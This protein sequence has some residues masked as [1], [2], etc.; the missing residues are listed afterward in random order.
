M[1][2]ATASVAAVVLAALSVLQVMVAA[3]R[4]YG[5]LVWGGAH[6]VLPRRLRVGSALSVLVYAAI[7]VAL[8]WR[9]GAFGEPGIVAAVVAWVI[10]GYFALGIVLNALSRSRAERLTMTPTCAVLAVCSLIVALG[11]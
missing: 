10:V 7:A 11:L 4:P 6:D 9:A 8:F 3:G 5:R 2:I 1:S